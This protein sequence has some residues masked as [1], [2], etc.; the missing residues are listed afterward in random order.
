[1][2][3]LAHSPNVPCALLASRRDFLN[4]ARGLTVDGLRQAVHA[5]AVFGK[6]EKGL[7]QPGHY[8]VT[9]SAKVP[10]SRLMLS[11]PPRNHLL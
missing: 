7:T 5:D 6:D 2:A 10:T 9:L 4:L 3:T 1:L 11:R 8:L